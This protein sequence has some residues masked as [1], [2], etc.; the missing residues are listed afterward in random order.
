MLKNLILKHSGYLLAGL[1]ISLVWLL[2]WLMGYS[3]IFS[4][5]GEYLT[6]NG[7]KE[8]DTSRCLVAGVA[9]MTFLFIYFYCQLAIFRCAIVANTKVFT[10]L[11]F[12]LTCKNAI[13]RFK[14]FSIYKTIFLVPL[15]LAWTAHIAISSLLML[16]KDSNFMGDCDNVLD[17]SCHHEKYFFPFM[18]LILISG[19]FYISALFVTSFSKTPPKKMT[20][21]S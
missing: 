3:A 18:L 14:D 7:W 2:I 13:A 15:L 6:K 10:P 19:V 16:I 1:L 5:I 11:H 8:F 12:Y 4:Y 20:T 17:C 21:T 9:R